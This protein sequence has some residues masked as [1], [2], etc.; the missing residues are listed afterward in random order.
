MGTICTLGAAFTSTATCTIFSTN[1]FVVQL[2]GMTVVS[3]TSY[4]LSLFPINTPDYTASP[5]I[6]TIT[7]YQSSN[8]YQKPKVCEAPITLPAF[9]LPT[10][11][12][13]TLVVTADTL[14]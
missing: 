10:T 13:C 6:A 3:T 7:S 14:N 12:S 9:S 2:N 4:S 8:V 1:M 5:M 11:S